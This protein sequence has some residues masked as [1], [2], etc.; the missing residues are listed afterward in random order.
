MFRAKY[1]DLH[2][3][4]V[5]AASISNKVVNEVAP[6]VELLSAESDATGERRSSALQCLATIYISNAGCS[7]NDAWQELFYSALEHAINNTDQ[8]SVNNHIDLYKAFF[9]LAYKLGKI[10]NLVE[11]AQQMY[12]KF[13]TDT[14]SLEWICKIFVEQSTNIRAGLTPQLQLPIEVFSDVSSCFALVARAIY[15][16]QAK[17]FVQSRDLLLKGKRF[18]FDRWEY[19]MFYRCLQLMFHK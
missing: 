5:K 14:H 3:K 4:L 1:G 18:V 10:N 7:A 19:F 17:D 6:F 2:S 11:K 12:V 13:P 9:K 15:W 8:Q 16:Y